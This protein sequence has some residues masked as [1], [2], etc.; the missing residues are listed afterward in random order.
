MPSSRNRIRRL[1]MTAPMGLL[2]ILDH[3]Y[4]QQLSAANLWAFNDEWAALA[5]V[6]VGLEQDL[7]FFVE[8]EV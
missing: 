8:L 2:V 7:I 6:R 1:G 3:Q 4:E 5:Q